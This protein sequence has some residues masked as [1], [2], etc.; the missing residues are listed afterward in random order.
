MTDRTTTQGPTTGREQPAGDRSARPS[1]PGGS[2]ATG[3]G[4][5]ESQTDA[6]ERERARRAAEDIKTAAKDAAAS[7]AGAVRT[8]IS[9]ELDYRKY[10]SRQRLAKV[11]NV[12][13][14]TGSSLQD[15]DEVVARYAERAAGRIERL[16]E[17]LDRKD[18]D[19]IL[20]DTRH[21]A[22][23]RPELFVGS[24][25]VAGLMLG[26]FL[27]SSS[28]E[29]KGRGDGGRETDTR[30]RDY[31]AGAHSSPTVAPPSGT[32]GPPNVTTPSGGLVP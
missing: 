29:P 21:M 11:A 31:T 15:E 19:E 16:A 9:G 5:P 6:S 2:A 1:G 13:R 28:P 32:A 12:L 18:I 25:F 4:S 23:Q 30:G 22:R 24:L 3:T 10:K 7:T 17:Y 20:T 26:R 14:E 27:R 8:R